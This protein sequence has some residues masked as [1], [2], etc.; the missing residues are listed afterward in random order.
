MCISF[1]VKWWE[2]LW[3]GLY[4]TVTCPHFSLRTS[5]FSSPITSLY[6]PW[7]HSCL[8]RALAPL[9]QNNFRNQDLVTRCA[10]LLQC[11]CTQGC[12]VYR[13]RK[14]ICVYAHTSVFISIPLSDLPLYIPTLQSEERNFINFT[15]IN[16]DS[17]LEGPTLLQWVTGLSPSEETKF[18]QHTKKVEI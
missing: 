5:I 4:V 16:W 2:P 12:S 3:A 1:E 9:R 13:T 7:N 6:K 15:L 10:Q 11:D 18:L 8:Q 17:D 14:Q